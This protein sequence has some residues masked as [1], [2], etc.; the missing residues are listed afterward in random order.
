MTLEPVNFWNYKC[1][2]QYIPILFL[3][4]VLNN[5]KPT[6]VLEV[7]VVCVQRHP[8]HFVGQ[9]IHWQS[10]QPILDNQSPGKLMRWTFPGP[11]QCTQISR[12]RLRLCRLMGV[13]APADRST[14]QA[15][16][17]PAVIHL[18]VKGHSTSRWLESIR[19]NHCRVNFHG[20]GGCKTDHPR[21]LHEKRKRCPVP[22]GWRT[23]AGYRWRSS[24]VLCVGHCETSVP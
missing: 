17:R 18:P 23:H 16:W 2:F 6:S 21:P 3:H 10:Y 9:W 8:R 12:Q 5:H 14:V 19:R 15:P 22:K 4:P 7:V 20:Q 1:H 13:H 24:K 11:I